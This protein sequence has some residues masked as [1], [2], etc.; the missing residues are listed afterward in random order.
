MKTL[1]LSVTIIVLTSIP[2]SA[3]SV[4]VSKSDISVYENSIETHITNFDEIR[5]S[6]PD[7]D[8]SCDL[9]HSPFA[10][11]RV[12]K[13]GAVFII[14]SVGETMER[15]LVELK[16]GIYKNYGVKVGN[17]INTPEKLFDYI[18][19]NYGFVAINMYYI[20]I[21]I[22][23]VTTGNDYRLECESPKKD[24]SLGKALDA[25]YLS[26]IFTYDPNL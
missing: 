18:S 12:I 10:Y 19:R 4:L 8:V 5:K 1:F 3:R 24:L 15:S 6:R 9:K 13:E 11:P 25:I 23:S 21:K 7:L 2:A 20:E 16:A 17:E 14:D 26:E 22:I